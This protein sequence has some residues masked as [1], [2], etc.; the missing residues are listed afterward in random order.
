[1]KTLPKNK[2]ILIGA[3]LFLVIMYVILKL[4]RKPAATTTGNTGANISTGATSS[5]NI[6]N[7][8]PVADDSF[9]LHD[10]SKGPNVKYLQQA[11]NTINE[12]FPNMGKY[13]PLVV[14]GSYGPS[15]YQAILLLIGTSALSSTGLS[16]QSFNAILKRANNLST[17]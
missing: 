2:K 3:L 11:L 7:P 1:M 9:P 6:Q 4:L 15:T 10:G 13:T 14:D 12:K 16:E 5:F 17:T 8:A